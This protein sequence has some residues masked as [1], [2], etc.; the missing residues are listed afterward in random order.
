MKRSK[1]LWLRSRYGEDLDKEQDARADLC[2][3][4]SSHEDR[5]RFAGRK[6]TEAMKRA[7]KR[8]ERSYTSNGSG[9]NFPLL[10][11]GEGQGE[12]LAAINYLLLFF[13]FAGEGNGAFR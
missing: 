2:Q 3:A 6:F 9:L 13:F 11:Y 5:E 12:G 8:Q 10:P 7:V 4:M 1:S